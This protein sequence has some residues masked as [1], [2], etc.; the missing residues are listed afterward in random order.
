MLTFNAAGVSTWTMSDFL[1]STFLRPFTL[2]PSRPC[3]GVHGAVAILLRRVRA[4]SRMS[5]R[6]ELVQTFLE[7]GPSSQGK[8][9]AGVGLAKVAKMDVMR[10]AWYSRCSAVVGRL[11]DPVLE[12]SWRGVEYFEFQLWLLFCYF[13]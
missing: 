8:I 11:I 4:T 7:G 3:D 9:R 1:N 12:I 10:N 6:Q 2:W 5:Y 13:A